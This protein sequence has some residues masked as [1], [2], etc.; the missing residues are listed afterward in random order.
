MSSSMLNSSTDHPK[1]Q[2]E[3]GHLGPAA[4]ACY[5]H[6]PRFR[7]DPPLIRS[8]RP[9]G[10]RSSP[11]RR[12]PPLDRRS[13]QGLAP[14]ANVRRQLTTVVCRMSESTDQN[15]RARASD[16]EEL[17][18][19]LEPL[20]VLLGQRHET[21]ARHSGVVFEERQSCLLPR[22]YRTTHHDSQHGLHPGV[23]THA[24]MDHVV[25]RAS[26]TRLRTKAHLR[27]RNLR[28]HGERLQSFGSI[29]INEEFVPSHV[30]PERSSISRRTLERGG[31]TPRAAPTPRRGRRSA[32][33]R[34]LFGLADSPTT[35]SPAQA[36][37]ADPR[38]RRSRA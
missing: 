15:P 29:A 8:G 5:R 23:F 16:V 7:E 2:L 13:V 18:R 19:L 24:L 12:Y 33:P 28:P 38:R 1:S 14:R 21:F 20:I 10:R 11:V 30:E 9:L 17:C 36:G 6:G 26:R 34:A 37:R 32:E 3:T 4:E 22:K 27:V 25:Q 31:C 35:A